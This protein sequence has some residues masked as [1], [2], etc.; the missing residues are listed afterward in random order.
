MTAPVPPEVNDFLRPAGEDGGPPPPVD[1]RSDTWAAVV[2][3]ARKRLA[4]HRQAMDMPMQDQ[5][6]RDVLSG[7]IAEL[8]D[9]LSIGKTNS[10]Q[11]M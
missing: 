7:R 10:S 8:T 3:I 4:D 5:R 6:M 2:L 11:G 9:L 1:V